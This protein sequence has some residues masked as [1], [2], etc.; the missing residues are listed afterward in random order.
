[1]SEFNSK[2][3]YV[4]IFSVLTII[5]ISYFW[6][7]KKIV[8]YFNITLFLKKASAYTFTSPKVQI[9]QGVCKLLN[10]SYDFIAGHYT[11]PE[12]GTKAQSQP[13]QGYP[14]Y[15]YYWPSCPQK[16][17]DERE[18]FMNF[19]SDGGFESGEN[20]V[21]N[22]EKTFL[23]KEGA[24]TIALSRYELDSEKRKVFSPYMFLY[25]NNYNAYLT[26]NPILGGTWNSFDK[27]KMG[28][29][30]YFNDKFS[31][32]EFNPEYYLSNM[33]GNKIVETDLNSLWLRY[34]YEGGGEYQLNDPSAFYYRNGYFF[35]ADRG[36]HRI[37]KYGRNPAV[38]TTIGKR[39][40]DW[41]LEGITA[42]SDNVVYIT[43]SVRNIVVKID[44]SNNY[45]EESG[46]NYYDEYREYLTRLY[47]TGEE[48][49]KILN[50]VGNM[51][52][53]TTFF[54]S[55]FTGHKVSATSTLDFIDYDPLRDKIKMQDPDNKLFGNYSY[56]FNGRERLSIPDHESWSFNSE[57][58]TID[59]WLRFNKIENLHTFAR[60]TGNFSF[61]WDKVN[62]EFLFIHKGKNQ[63][64]IPYV[65]YMKL[66]SD[67][68]PEVD[69]WYHI[70][71]VRTESKEYAPEE[72]MKIYK[73]FIDG[74]KIAQ[75]SAT[76]TLISDNR[77]E[78]EVGV[79]NGNMDNFRITKGIARWEE[80]FVPPYE[81]Y[82]PKGIIAVGDYLY[83]A[84]SG[85]NR[86]VKMSADFKEWTTFGDYG[87]GD[88]QFN[89]PTDIYYSEGYFYI[90]DSGNNRVI[91]TDIKTTSVNFKKK[92][93]S[94]SSWQVIYKWDDEEVFYIEHFDS[95]VSGWSGINGA[96]VVR[97]GVGGN[98][99]LT[100][101]GGKNCAAD[102]N[103]G[104]AQK[105]LGS[106]LANRLYANRKLYVSFQYSSPS[107]Q[108]VTVQF[109]KHPG[110]SRVEDKTNDNL[111]LVKKVVPAGA[112]GLEIVEF[113]FPGRVSLDELEEVYLT[114][115]A[116]GSFSISNIRVFVDKEVEF[117]S[118]AVEGNNWYVTD[119][120]NGT[121]IKNGV[122]IGG[123]NPQNP[124]DPYDPKFRFA[125]P[126]DILPASGGKVYI[127]DAVSNKDFAMHVNGERMMESFGT[128]QEHGVAM[129][130]NEGGLKVTG[131]RTEGVFAKL[132]KEGPQ[133]WAG[134]DL[135]PSISNC[136]AKS[137]ID[138]FI[139]GHC[140]VFE[141]T[142]KL[143]CG[144]GEVSV[145]EIYGNHIKCINAEAAGVPPNECVGQYDWQKIWPSCNYWTGAGNW[146]KEYECIPCP[147]PPPPL[148]PNG[149]NRGVSI[150][151]NNFKVAIDEE[152]GGCPC[153]CI[154]HCWSWCEKVTLDCPI[155]GYAVRDR[156][157]YK[158]A[159]I[160]GDF[161]S[162]TIDLFYNQTPKTPEME[163]LIK[164]AEDGHYTPYKCK[165][166]RTEDC[167]VEK[168]K[169]TCYRTLD[170]IKN[171]LLRSGELESNK[172]GIID[173]E[174]YLNN[175]INSGK[176]KL[177]SVNVY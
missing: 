97:S 24:G 59:F 46:N 118:V 162:F 28:P 71:L 37:V 74:N 36:N 123:K 87:S 53:S 148:P 142:G 174:K 129:K 127:L 175:I 44:L 4:I 96:S 43:D 61:E 6:G 29:S 132:T 158:K 157:N 11:I 34:L 110:N 8:P 9:E 159:K 41:K 156:L 164:N 26:D 19:K 134:Y 14:V 25:S 27:L 111:N 68:N 98:G 67:W 100:V 13:F 80:N 85:N 149:N 170:E 81:F 101:S 77:N 112:S 126:V 54:D 106:F 20:I 40:W 117:N 49:I 146:K 64:Y 18:I 23:T 94:D 65:Q 56:Y 42:V 17:T 10:K 124:P 99:V 103:F 135:G 1:M 70:A 93:F 141:T 66:G 39:D 12:K 95:G 160:T 57:N 82:N 140:D 105:A 33:P 151:N 7:A 62:N 92:N 166:E 125:Y 108:E 169:A 5:F 22:G 51:A 86:I 84:D 35:I 120:H 136:E 55:G 63:Y 78:L 147:P 121:V 89:N 115:S 119:V 113:D 150:N 143:G 137:N 154:I 102:T 48:K 177:S 3:K 133:L 83:I 58:F 131:V 165:C 107:P 161:G 144:T 52:S 91:K 171:L 16:N 109:T 2:S 45:W 173:F 138:G 79:F 122:I 15:K 114:L 153:G 30:V 155:V 139:P 76:S 130:F 88:Y 145:A 47:L 128:D 69:T 116:C 73:L 176:I 21:I 104:A 75:S 168:C 50:K 72:N 152:C 32:L 31:K 90:T 172:E 167:N 60:Q 38:F 163:E